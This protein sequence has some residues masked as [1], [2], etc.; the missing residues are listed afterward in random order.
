MNLEPI[1]VTESQFVGRR[2]RSSLEYK[3]S[4]T[5]IQKES[6]R[7]R[8][9]VEDLLL[10]TRV[11]NYSEDI[12]W[13]TLDLDKLSREVCESKSL[14]K[15]NIKITMVSSFHLFKVSQRLLSIV[16]EIS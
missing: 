1:A 8:D 12:P 4:F 5:V 3:N 15:K 10:L 16:T 7:M 11:E 14:S 13:T 6:V 9:L 2:E